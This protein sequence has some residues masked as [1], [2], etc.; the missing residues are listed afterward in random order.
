MKRFPGKDII[1][2]YTAA[3]LNSN[4]RIF[5]Q[6][7]LSVEKI[8][9]LYPKKVKC[10]LC[11]WSGK[12]FLSDSW[13]PHTICPKCNSE[14]RHRL[15]VAAMKCIDN[16][17]LE[18]IVKEKVVLHFAPEKSVQSIISKHARVYITA[19]LFRGDM[20]LKLNI[21]NMQEVKSENVD[22]VIACDVLEH[23][24]DDFSAIHEIYRVL[25]FWGYAIITVPQKDGLEETYEDK[26]ITDPLVR[27]EKYG[28]YDHLRIYG[29]SFSSVLEK[30][31]FTVTTVS[32]NDFP[33]DI[34]RKHVL[35]PPV[36]SERPLATNH[37]KVYF[38][39]KRPEIKNGIPINY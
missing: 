23:V 22:V 30:E 31:G 2:I 36:L 8:C 3:V 37:R 15:L 20:D 34:V 21:T 16:L 13:H 33:D 5:Q 25:R 35:F 29:N 27:E 9:L 1:L 18:K 24:M 12:S 11:G 6:L 26:S 17:S 38:A 19:D 28:Q 7:R 39:Q 4:Y 32:E 14:V 10:N